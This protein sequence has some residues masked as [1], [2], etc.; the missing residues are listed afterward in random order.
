MLKKE[1]R[2]TLKKDFDSTFKNAQKSAFGRLAGLKAVVNNL[3][4]NRYGIIVSNRISKKATERNK[5]KRQIRSI[6]ETCDK[7][8]LPGH[9]IVLIALP[10][11][12]ESSYLLIRAE[13]LRLF[14]RTKL[15]I[16]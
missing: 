6:A 1:N 9:D 2:L 3:A 10:G 11:I 8:I 4:V 14:T 15:F 5:I 12:K 7:Q 16:K 13:L